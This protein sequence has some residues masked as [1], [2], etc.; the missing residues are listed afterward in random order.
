VSG[1]GERGGLGRRGEEGAREPGWAARGKGQ[2][3]LVWSVGPGG[4][5]K[6]RDGPGFSWAGFVWVSFP[7][8][9]LFPI[10]FLFLNLIQ[11]KFEFKFEFEFKPHSNKIMHQHE[12]NK[13]FKPKINF[14]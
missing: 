7:F 9:I 4:R 2:A 11:T 14:N 10:T 3:G 12:C 1:A 8:L 6:K 5:R 13:K